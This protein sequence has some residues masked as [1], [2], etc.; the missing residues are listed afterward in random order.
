MSKKKGHSK[1]KIHF[2]ECDIN[3]TQ[4]DSWDQIFPKMY[5]F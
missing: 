2:G 1:Q 4:K 5:I 3:M